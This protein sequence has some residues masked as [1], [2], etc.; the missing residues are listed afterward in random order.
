[1]ADTAV[2]VQTMIDNSIARAKD[3]N[4]TQWS[5]AQLLKFVNKAVDYVHK[6]LIRIKS[7]IAITDGTI[8]LSATQEYTLSGTLDDFWGMSEVYFDG[9]SAPLTPVSY[10]DKIR[11]A[12]STTDTNPLSYYLTATKLGLVK[13]PSATAAAAYPTLSCRYFKKNTALAL[14]DNMPYKNIFN[15][16][17]ALFMDHLALIKA[18]VPAEELTA[19]YNALEESTLDIVSKRIPV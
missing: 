10:E 18:E 14:G 1:M 15:E 17:I 6:L 3:S 12:G 2:T 16:P 5:D 8:T 13:T 7:E 19:L 9:V 4:K 11:E